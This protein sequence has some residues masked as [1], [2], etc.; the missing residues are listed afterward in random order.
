MRAPVCVAAAVVVVG[1]MPATASAATSPTSPSQSFEPM[2][3]SCIPC[4]REIFRRLGRKFFGPGGRRPRQ[5]ANRRGRRR[6]LSPRAIRRVVRRAYRWA[7][8]ASRRTVRWARRA[9]GRLPRTV[10]YCIHG[11]YLA[12]GVKPSYVVA[13]VGCVGGVFVALGRAARGRPVPGGARGR[14]VVYAV[15]S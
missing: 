12:W 9:F 6:G 3:Y 15:P 1:L 13:A 2:R 7:R 5:E 4:M 11:A 14:A 10:R 8:R